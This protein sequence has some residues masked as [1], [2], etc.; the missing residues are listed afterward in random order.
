MLQM[1]RCKRGGPLQD[2]GHYREVTRRNH[3][4]T[5]I[6]GE[7]VQLGVVPGGET[8]RA[9]DYIRPPTAVNAFCLTA[10][11]LV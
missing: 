1:L 10:A 8:A 5:P 6:A 2:R 9:D 4:H 7:T 11:A 3:T